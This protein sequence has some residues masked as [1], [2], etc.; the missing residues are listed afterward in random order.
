MRW[1]II[2][3]RYVK[4]DE[5]RSSMLSK[6]I[7]TRL[8]ELTKEEKEILEKENIDYNLY[9][10]NTKNVIDINNFLSKND[11]ITIRKHTRFIDFPEH[12]HNYVEIQYVYSGILVQYCD[13]KKVELTSGQILFLNQ[14]VKHR[15]L[16]SNKDDIIINLLIKPEFFNYLFSLTELD[17]SLFNFLLRALY[18]QDKSAEFL[19]FKVASIREIQEAMAEIINELYVP[20]KNRDIHDMLIKLNVAKLFTLLIKHIDALEMT[21]T[22]AYE[23]NTLYKI[24]NYIEHNY[25]KGSLKELSNELNLPDYKISKTIKTNIG[26]NFVD[27]IQSKRIEIAT[28]LLTATDIPISQIA[29]DVGYENL[30]YFYKIFKQAYKMTPLN[31]RKQKKESNN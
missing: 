14:D 16:K 17:N 1:I 20:S 10:L 6:E 21:T 3:F 5:R 28:D 27:L 31:Y 18:R 4:I 25:K 22:N 15:I 8:F 24:L 30:T 9:S 11:F 12:T 26:V 19:H 29:V 13:E 7:E 23:V 2:N